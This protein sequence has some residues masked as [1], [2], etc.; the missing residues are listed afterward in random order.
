M[1]VC[2]KGVEFVAC[3]SVLGKGGNVSLNGFRSKVRSFLLGHRKDGAPVIQTEWGPVDESYRKQAALNMKADPE[4]KKRVER[5]FIKRCG[6]R[7]G[8]GLIAC[9]RQFPEAYEDS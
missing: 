3:A 6:G 1:L 9:R 5:H 2:I 4:I 7:T 8:E